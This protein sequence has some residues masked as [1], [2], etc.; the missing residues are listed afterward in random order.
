MGISKAGV[1]FG[2]VPE[3]ANQLITG[4]GYGYGYGDGSGSGSGDGSGYGYGYGWRFGSGYGSGYGSGDGSGYGYGDGSGYGYGYGSGSGYGYGYGYGSGYG[5]GDGS[6]YGYGDGSGYGYGDGY[7]YWL[8]LFGMASVN[9][10]E[11]QRSRLAILEREADTLAFWKSDKH[12]RPANGG[13]AQEA[14]APG[15]VQ[16]VPGPLKLCQGGTLHA[17]MNPDKWQGERLWVVALFGE[18]QWQ[19]DK[20]GA[21]KREIIGEIPLKI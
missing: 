4:D 2:V 21:L 19:D 13:Y 9:W 3:W 17:T 14:A 8:R 12:G 6:G 20:C 11:S 15:L 10:S 5:S 1:V 16:T 18:I 7:G